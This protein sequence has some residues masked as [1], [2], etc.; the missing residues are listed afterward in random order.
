MT[1]GGGSII[2]WTPLY[3][4]NNDT[5]TTWALTPERQRHNDLEHTS[6]TTNTKDA[7]YK[8]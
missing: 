2:N 7:L 6:G 8:S 1:P 4:H 5:L 3:R